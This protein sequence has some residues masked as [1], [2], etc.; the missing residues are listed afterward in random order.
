MYYYLSIFSLFL[1][2]NSDYIGQIFLRRMILLPSS[3]FVLGT[4]ITSV[5][6]Y[7][8]F[9]IFFL[10]ITLAFHKEW[11][12]L[13]I[14]IKGPGIIKYLHICFMKVTSHIVQKMN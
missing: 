1:K 13:L 10:T 5:L 2:D 8:W 3:L 11:Y 12:I 14:S 7:S 9:C 4:G 6:Y